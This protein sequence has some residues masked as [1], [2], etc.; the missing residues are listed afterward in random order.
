MIAVNQAGVLAPVDE[1]REFYD[2]LILEDCAHACYANAGSNYDAAVWSFQAVKTMPCG[3]GGMITTNSKE[4]Y[5]KLDTNDLV[6][7]Y[8][9][10]FKIKKEMVFAGKPL[11]AWDY[12]VDILGYKAYMIDLT[13]AIFRLEQMKKLDKNLEWRRHIQS[14]I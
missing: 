12:D 6:R 5:E 11:Y 10:I 13:A 7:Y 9:H 14:Q 4:L 2:G 1:I 8:K 3:D